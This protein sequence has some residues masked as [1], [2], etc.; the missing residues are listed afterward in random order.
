[1]KKLLLKLFAMGAAVCLA[2]CGLA[3]CGKRTPGPAGNGQLDAID[4]ESIRFVENSDAFTVSWT[5]PANATAY[6]VTVGAATVT[7]SARALSLRDA[8]FTLPADGNITVSIV[9]KSDLYLDSDPTK[10]SYTAEGAQLRSPEILSFENNVLSWSQVPFASGYKVTVNGESADSNVSGST[11]NL[12]SY[13]GALTVAITAIGDG[14]YLKDSTTTVNVNEDHSKLVFGAIS[15]FT[16]KD[17]VL[18]WGPMGG[19][20]AYRVVDVDRNSTV[21]TTTEF[22]M[23]ETNVIVGV[24][25]VSA[26]DII[27]DAEV[28]FNNPLIPYLE[29]SGTTAEPYLIRTAFDLRA[30]DYYEDYYYFNTAT[31]KKPNVYRIENDIDYNSVGVSEDKSNIVY[32]NKPFFG[33]L[34]GNGKKLSNIR[35]IY[36][37]GYWALFDHIAKGATV[38]NIVFDSPN[39]NNDGLSSSKG[40]PIDAKTATV[41]YVNKGTISGITVQNATYTTKLGDISGIA[42][43]NYGTISG[44]TVKQ[45]RFKNA[46]NVQIEIAG[47]AVENYVGGVVKTDNSVTAVTAQG[48]T[49]S[50]LVALDNRK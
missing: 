45:C 21:I 42:S 27:G 33:T 3:A 12:S 48:G 23:S 39:I 44:C 4:A 17:G 5:P 20:K 30:I 43:K 13:S 41:A 35:V 36:N 15:S 31:D 14:F 2:L 10:K 40:Y 24:Y 1:M 22:D 7:T 29:G 19:A 26:L 46:H 37:D 49:L 28:D 11:V 6:A 25:P 8:A 34:D 16:V 18:S 32:L 9:A 47:I 50:Q 38:K